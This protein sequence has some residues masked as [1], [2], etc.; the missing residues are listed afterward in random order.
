MTAL[1]ISPLHP[2]EGSEEARRFHWDALRASRWVAERTAERL[3]ASARLFDERISRHALP[4]A[5]VT[6]TGLAFFG[7]GGE[8]K[9][10]TPDQRDLNEKFLDGG[11][12]EPLLDRHNTHL[13]TGRWLHAFACRAG[14]TLLDHTVAAGATCAVGY[15]S[16]L[17]MEWTP[18]DVEALPPEIREAFVSL[19]TGV[20]LALAGGEVEATAL[21]AALVEA[22]GRLMSWCDENPGG[23]PGLEILAQQLVARM[24]V[25]RGA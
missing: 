22:Q 10:L 3:V 20:T 2:V 15:E 5:L 23:A 1:L 17:I 13:L 24:A 4:E 18:E 21:C 7:H 19:T 8:I 6:A 14:T 16:V 11:H 9:T 12:P 25:R